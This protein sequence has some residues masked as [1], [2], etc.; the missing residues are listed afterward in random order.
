MIRCLQ[1]L[2]MKIN[3]SGYKN[4]IKNIMTISDKFQ[5]NMKHMMIK[6]TSII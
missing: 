2:S 6:T 5:I 4:L 3:N 1:N